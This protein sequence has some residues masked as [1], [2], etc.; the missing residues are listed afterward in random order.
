V[1]QQLNSAVT[2]RLNTAATTANTFG[3]QQESRP[4]TDYGVATVEKTR[5]ST[6]SAA[7]KRS[8]WGNFHPEGSNH[9]QSGTRSGSLSTTDPVAYEWN[10]P[11]VL[12][13]RDA[14]FA[15]DEEAHEEGEEGE[16]EDELDRTAAVVLAEQG[17]GEIVHGEGKDVTDLYIPQGKCF[18]P[19]KFFFFLSSSDV[20]FTLQPIDL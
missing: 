6:S 15:T 20:N 4:M 19:S 5:W 12:G 17:H 16:E 2:A 10:H 11:V 18:R 7:S 14:E 3:P 13:E 8:S 1:E 9:R